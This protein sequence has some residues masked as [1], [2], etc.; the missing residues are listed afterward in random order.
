MKL[1]ITGICGFAGSVIARHLLD[2]SPGLAITGFD[3]LS[4]KGSEMNVEPLRALGVDVRIGDVR[5]RAF[6]GTLPAADWILDCAANPS[7]LAGV[8]GSDT[9][10][11]IDQNL[12]G[13][14]NLLEL[15]KKWTAGFILLSTSRVY[16]IPPLAGLPLHETLTRF[17]PDLTVGIVDSSLSIVNQQ[18]QSANSDQQSA[19]SPQ[20]T[21]GHSINN[22]QSTISNRQCSIS[23]SGVTESFPTTPPVSLYGATKLCSEL[24]ALEYGESFGFPVWINRCGVLAGA[25]QFG[26]ADQGIFSYWIHSWRAGRPLKYI[27]FGGKGLQV[28]DCLHPKD[29]VP[30][31]LKQMAACNGCS[32]TAMLSKSTKE[33][34][35]DDSLLCSPVPPVANPSSPLCPPVPPVAKSSLPRIINVSGGLTNS[36]SLLE[37]SHWCQSRFGPHPSSEYL[38]P[39]CASCGKSSRE[40]RPFDIPWLVLDASLAKA[41]WDWSPA[42]PINDILEDIAQHAE[43]NPDWLDLVT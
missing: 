31:L 9:R 29:L 38:V 41:T 4:R 39:S 32:A 2:D 14:I 30:L 43:S 18:N 19:I 10:D 7:V 1:L 15:C 35:S 37:L 25:G 13:T 40:F 22:E 27:G 33:I 34:R 24:L 12:Y 36:M 17:V 20:E 6:L 3:N 5:D 42:T 28:R 21:T 16:S 11:L 23:P 26:K 8:D